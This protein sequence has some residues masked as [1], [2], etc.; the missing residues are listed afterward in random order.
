MTERN[1]TVAD[2]LAEMRA[3]DDENYEH[4]SLIKEWANRIESALAAEKPPL[5]RVNAD[6][7]A[8][9]VECE[10]C[11]TLAQPAMA[12]GAVPYRWL[13]GDEA[14]HSEAE[15][16]E[17]IRQWGPSD[18]IVTP[19]YAHAPPA[20]PV[21]SLGRDAEPNGELDAVLRGRGLPTVND[22]LGYSRNFA[23]ANPLLS[24]T[25]KDHI[26]GLCDMLELAAGQHAKP[27]ASVPD[28][29]LAATRRLAFAARTSG[30]TAGHDAELC[31]ALDAIEA[32]L[33]TT[34]EES[35]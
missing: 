21:E 19:V 28:G 3:P 26:N 24:Q 32:I 35:P 30:G 22:A 6:D 27:P 33:A 2:V 11:A 29:L 5:Y 34:P 9:I 31:A 1:E 7:G 20:V 17:A 13:V 4:Y 12:A 15:A 14:F 10:R 8:R 16:I 23:A 18:A 25:T